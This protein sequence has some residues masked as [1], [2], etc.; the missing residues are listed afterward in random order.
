VR[1]RSIER[2]S[3]LSTAGAEPRHE[4][5]LDRDQSANLFR[6]VVLPH[7]ADGLAL[8]RWLAGNQ[9]DAEDIL[10]ES[11]VRALN[12]IAGYDGGNARAWMLAIV[13]NT[14]FSWLAKQ[15]SSALVLAGGLDDVDEAAQQIDG[16][17]ADPQPT[18][19]GEL[20]RRS[21][22]KAVE[23][24]IEALPLPFREVVILR[25]VNGLNYKEIA[26]LL[27]LPI[28]T[29]MSRLARGRRQLAVLV[30][31]NSP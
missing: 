14:A 7:L 28:G 30:G 16:G 4:D 26:D 12:A 27:N 24:A 31:S 13:R 29:V 21:D 18:P 22:A 17:G 5:S 9:A 3:K 11:C 23:R 15:R 8:A 25:D 19:E 6:R 1:L 20:I 10:Q 2:G